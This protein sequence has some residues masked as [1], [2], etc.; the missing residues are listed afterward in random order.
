MWPLWWIFIQL[1]YLLCPHNDFVWLPNDFVLSQLFYIAFAMTTCDSTKTC[2]PSQ[3]V[4]VLSQWL[5]VT[6]K[7][8]LHIFIMNFVPL[9]WLCVPSQW[10]CGSLPMTFLSLTMTF[11][12]TYDLRNDILRPSL[13][14][15]CLH[16]DSET[17]MMTIW[18]SHL[19]RV[20]VAVTYCILKLID[21]VCHLRWLFVTIIITCV[22]SRDF[23]SNSQIY[24][25]LSDFLWSS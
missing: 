5:F 1:Q 2:V 22:P 25:I 21:S 16:D 7:M 17:L 14:L 4:S 6:F 20:T 15:V 3:W 18:L 12:N 23:V 10:L 19:L 24:V 13:F 8:T 11:T 9:Q